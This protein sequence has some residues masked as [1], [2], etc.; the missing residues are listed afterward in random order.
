[1]SGLV[2]GAQCPPRAYAFHQLT[3]RVR[4]AGGARETD[5][6]EHLLPWESKYNPGEGVLQGVAQILE[7][8]ARLAGFKSQLTG[9]VTL[10]NSFRLS[11][12][13]FP[14]L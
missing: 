5:E 9:C 3:L 8:G 1:M 14:H 10:D 4:G 12:P 2:Q 7:S 6:C 13:Q 11:V